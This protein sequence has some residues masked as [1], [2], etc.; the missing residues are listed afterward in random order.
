M[1][2]HSETAQA[3]VR[4]ALNRTSTAKSASDRYS[5]PRRLRGHIGPSGRGQGSGTRSPKTGAGSRTTAPVESCC[6]RSPRGEPATRFNDDS[7]LPFHPMGSAAMGAFRAHARHVRA[8]AVRWWRDIT[9]TAPGRRVDAFRRHNREQLPPGSGET[10]WRNW[11]THWIFAPIR[12]ISHI[13]GRRR[14]KSGA[15]QEA[16]AEST[17]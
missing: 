10:L 17:R 3:G 4:G 13:V 8:I 11:Q 15:E 14:C 9:Q 2:V 6:R 16:H 1:V 7:P 12:F 5:A